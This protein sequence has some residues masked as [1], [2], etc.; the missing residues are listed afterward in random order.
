[1]ARPTKD[2][3]WATAGADVVEP[4][5]GRKDVGWE[6]DAYAIP[7]YLNWWQELVYDWIVYMTAAQ[8]YWG[9]DVRPLILSAH[10]CQVDDLSAIADGKIVSLTGGAVIA[11][12][13]IGSKLPAGAVVDNITVYGLEGNV[14]GETYDATVY[15][16][17]NEGTT[18]DEGGGTM[19]SGTT[20][21]QTNLAFT[22]INYTL[23]ETDG[24]FVKCTLATTSAGA[25]VTVNQIKVDWHYAYTP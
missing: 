2:P 25:E 15:S 17:D 1:M 4:N 12:F 23:T 22:A 9:S 7:E 6:N 3:R 14:G 16:V 13:D 11:R 20:N 24:L 18:T 10:D 19:T 21:A 5:E 8:E